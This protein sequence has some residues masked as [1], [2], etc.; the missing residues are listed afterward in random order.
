M[1]IQQ[2]T[3]VKI[4]DAILHVIEEVFEKFGKKVGAEDIMKL[5]CFLCVAV[6][7]FCLYY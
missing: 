5:I 6:Q 1:I 4:G 7:T 2:I 3:T